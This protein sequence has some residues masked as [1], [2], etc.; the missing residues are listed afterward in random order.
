MPQSARQQDPNGFLLVKGC[1]ISSY[2]VFQY[3][4]AQVGL[5]DGDPNRI[6]NVYRPESAVNDPQLIASLQHVPL[7][8][9]HEMLS[10]FDGDESATAPEE[11]GIDGVLFDISY[12]QPWLRGDVKVFTRKMQGDLQNGKKDLSL[13][14]T[15]DF[16]LQNGT[17]NGQPYE[18]VQTNMRGNHIALVSAGRVPGAKVLDGKHVLCY[19]HLDVNPSPKEHPMAKKRVTSMDADVVENLRAQLKALLPA[20]EQFLNQEAAEPAHAAPAD[21]NAAAA[22]AQPAAPAP[23]ATAAAAP[24]APAA[25][26]PPAAPAAAAPAAP[27]A[28]AAPPQ[29]LPGLIAQLEAV[30]EQL[31]AQ[32]GGGE[33]GGEGAPPEGGEGGEGGDPSASAESDPSSSE[34]DPMN[35]SS[36]EDPKPE[37]DAVEGLQE[38]PNSEQLNVDSASGDE[39]AACEGNGHASPGPA[40]GK[41]TGADAALRAVYA[42]TAKKTKLYGRLSKVV[43]AFDGAMDIA[44]ATAADVAAYGIKKLKLTAP[45]GQEAAVLDAYLKGV[46]AARGSG[47]APQQRA[48]GD[49]AE[50]SVPAI[51]AY[52][53]E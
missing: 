20:F 19:D 10:G 6:V 2:G 25:A 28:A 18:V 8:N 48:T 33:G 27:A 38:D 46:E 12:Q 49:S 30:L 34:G 26:V 31:K 21:P 15:C 51:A 37:G 16:Q 44:T 36:T 52:F 5:K 1:P 39:G 22:A 17:Y 29:D 3:S 24:A 40:A 7:I 43:G 13:G 4:A 35:E 23:D 41:H 50:S 42:D 53:K 32:V 9:D 47:A 45:K 11:Y 14:Y